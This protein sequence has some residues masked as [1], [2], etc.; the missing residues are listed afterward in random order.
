MNRRLWTHIG[1]FVATFS[2]GVLLVIVWTLLLENNTLR[3][4]VNNKL[5]CH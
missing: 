5:N 1:T 3:L 2:I 4:V